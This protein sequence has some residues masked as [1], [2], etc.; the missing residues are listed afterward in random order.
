MS[1]C[2]LT[3]GIP[4]Y[5]DFD[6]AYFTLQA[7]RLYHDLEGAE[8]LVVDNSP[9]TAA[10]KA[11]RG[12]VEGWS[13][14]RYVAAPLATGPAAA[15][16]LVFRHA[17]GDA[18][19]VMDCHVL[20]A[21]GSLN[22]LR[23]YYE[24]HPET[25]D[26]LTGP[27]VYDNLRDLSTHFDNRWRGE[28]WGT[29]GRAWRCRCGHAF[30][31][32]NGIARDLFT[33]EPLERCPHCGAAFAPP[34]RDHESS[35]S[36]LRRDGCTRVADVGDSRPIRIPAHGCGLLSCRR[37]AWLGFP[38]TWRGFGGEEFYI[39]TKFQQAG[40][41]VVLLP[42]LRWLH[43]FG[44]PGGVR[45]PLSRY[46]KVRNYVLGHQELGIP[47]DR[48]QEHFVASGLMPRDEWEYLLADPVAHV[49]PPPKHCGGCASKQVQAIAA[50]TLDELYTHAWQTP[51]DI[52]AHCPK[53]RELAAQCNHVTEFGMRKAVSTVALLAGQPATLVSYSAGEEPIDRPLKE[54]QGKT[55]YRPLV[56][57]SLD[58]E[59]EPTDLLF[60]DTRHTAEHLYAELSRHAG[61]VSR[62]I[63]LH[64]T[65]IF[66]ERGEDG[67]PGLLPALRRFL[68]EKPEWSVVF[69]SEANHGL[70]VIGCRPEDK[71]KLPGAI[72]LA[73]N[74]A[75]AV[76][77]HVADGLQQ[78]DAEVL[79]ARLA[80]CT[81]CEQRSADRCSVCGCYIAKKAAWRTS[82]CPLGQWPEVSP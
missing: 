8:L 69:H 60:L 35:E 70:T 61:K 71:P 2:R 64:D 58:V 13:D 23:S 25:E 53:L 38:E 22:A 10:G 72:T 50:K 15:K 21:P 63:V 76:A 40:R 67:G 9:D 65:Q 62:W 82:E 27:L 33:F 28:M 56:G 11:V 43:R 51:S 5:E 54:K 37:D 79:E 41:Q 24:E 59:I 80:R 44:R 14:G 17:R 31:M 68:R 7:L 4:H 26:L 49:D 48:V 1:D 47:L 57:T 52:H 19:L 29:W 20:L 18:V 74:F 46:A 73:A 42:G 75:K 39:H 55:N 16:D 66:G 77:E 30:S 3:I 81:L 32:E 12:L 45:Y 34:P 36:S 6:G 78:V